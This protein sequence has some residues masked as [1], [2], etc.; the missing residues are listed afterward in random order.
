M[1]GMNRRRAVSVLALASIASAQRTRG[2]FV[3]VWR[4]V[5][6]EWKDK[7]TGEVRYP[8]G[9]KPIGRL[10]Y[11]AE[12]RFAAQLMDPGRR[13]IGG[14]PTSSF[15]GALRDASPEDMREL[16]AGFASY[17]GTYDIDESSQTVT[18]HVQAHLIPSF[19]G[20]DLHRKYEFSGAGQLILTAASDQGVTRLTW[21]L[22]RG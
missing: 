9:P 7:P 8:Y 18:H 1:T 22:D 4:L 16:L 20:A 21:Q 19:V 2:Q 14:P 6:S 5:S 3:G 10:T 11:D 12:R 13:K 15:V 17:F